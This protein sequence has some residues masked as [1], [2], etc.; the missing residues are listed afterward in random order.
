MSDFVLPANLANNEFRVTV[1]LEIFNAN[2]ISDLHSNQEGIV[3]RY[4]VGV[5]P[6]IM[7]SVDLK[8]NVNTHT[9]ILVLKK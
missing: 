2:L 6:E 9:R 5:G 7:P 1:C 4:V 8:Y 3:L